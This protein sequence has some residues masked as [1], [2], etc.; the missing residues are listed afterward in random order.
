MQQFSVYYP[1]V[2]LQLSMFRAFSRPSSGA[3]R[4]QYQPL[5]L[6]LYRGDS[7]PRTQHG[8]HHDT[9]VKP[10][11]ATAVVEILM[12][13]GVIY[14]NC[15]M[16]HGLTNLKKVYTTC[17]IVSI[18]RWKQTQFSKRR[19]KYT[20]TWT[21]YKVQISRLNTASY[22]CKIILNSLQDKLLFF[23]LVEFSALTNNDCVMCLFC[24]LVCV[25]YIIWSNSLGWS[26]TS[27]LLLLVYCNRHW[28]RQEFS[29]YQPT[30]FL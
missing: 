13:G 27:V 10:E 25:P 3:Q 7:R 19:Q 16:M 18:W 20:K 12:I 11:A 14:L 5:V 23:A 30:W 8:Y 26:V 29:K 1:D 2:Y 4:L 24:I 6:T 22:L 28:E 9:K 15:T 17:G 21:T